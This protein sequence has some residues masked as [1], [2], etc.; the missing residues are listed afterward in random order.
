VAA[1]AGPLSGPSTTV[2]YDK[3]TPI[4]RGLAIEAD[5]LQHAAVLARSA[6]AAALDITQWQRLWAEAAHRAG[7]VTPPDEVLP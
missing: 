7:P 3:A 6:G 1:P 4:Q 2:P 5:A